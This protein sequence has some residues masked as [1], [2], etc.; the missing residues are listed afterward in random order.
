MIKYF[1]TFQ[2]FLIQIIQSIIIWRDEYLGGPIDYLVL[3]KNL[4]KLRF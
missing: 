2:P 4:M 3:Y 1:S